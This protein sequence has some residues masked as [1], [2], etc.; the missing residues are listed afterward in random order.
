MSTVTQKSITYVNNTTAPTITTKEIDL[1]TCYNDNEIVIKVHAA[2]INP[3]DGLT[4]SACNYFVGGSSL[5]TFGRD[6]A[7][8]IVR[9]GK[10]VNI[11]WQLNK[12]VNGQFKHVWGE[13]GSFTNYFV[14][15][16]EEVRSINTF[17][18][19]DD[20]KSSKKYNDFIINGAWPL[21]FGT[22]YSALHEKG[23][24]WTPESKIL[25]I[26]ASTSV[27]LACVNIAKKILN[28]GT[29][30]GICNSKAIEHN[31]E[32]GFDHLIAY[33]D[34][35]HSTV[36]SIQ[37]LIKNE[38]GGEKFDLI[39]DAVGSSEFFPV[40]DTVLKPK[41]TNSQYITIAGDAVMDFT[42]KSML[43][44]FQ[45]GP[46][47]RKLNPFKKFNYDFTMLDN[48]FTYME[49]GATMIADGT[50]SPEID[51]VYK[52]DDFKIAFDRVDTH[53]AKGKVVLDMSDI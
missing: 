22:G 26:G 11:K 38:L 28:I 47:K 33:N 14:C 49:L 48:L 17:E 44:N 36:E 25:V 8:V 24:V 30:V 32:R 41:S 34:P 43:G 50:Y 51:S 7:G 2:S 39:F 12:K 5:K 1:D 6:F 42:N 20:D 18:T 52:F 10:D 31:K 35:E 53:L 37:S 3:V 4:Y 13:K 45:L 29:V 27:A 15:N 21:V 23:Q 46:I 9:R 19:R 40:M 16:P